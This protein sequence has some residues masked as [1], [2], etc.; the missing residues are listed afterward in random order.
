MPLIFATETVRHSFHQ[1]PAQIQL[2]YN[3][4]EEMLSRMD[5]VLQID[6]VIRHGFDLE[7]IVRVA[8]KLKFTIPAVTE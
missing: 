1:L 3:G 7:I 5:R 2:D 8:E 6:A 4:L